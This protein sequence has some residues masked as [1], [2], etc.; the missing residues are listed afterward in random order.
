MPHVRGNASPGTLMIRPLKRA[1]AAIAAF[2]ALTIGAA[3]VSAQN[4]PTERELQV[5]AGLH[6]AAANGDVKELEELISDGEKIDLQDAS[7][8]TPLIVAA[9][10]KQ[11]AAAEALL[12]HGANVNAHDVQ[13]Y[14]ILTIAA[15]NNDVELAKLALTNGANAGAVTGTSSSTALISAAHLG[16]VEIL[17]LLIDAKAPLDH[18]NNIGWT[19]LITA[20]V[21]GN[22]SKEHVATVEALVKAGAN[23]DIKDRGGHT[24]LDYARQ[25]RYDDMVKIIE[26]AKG[27]KL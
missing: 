8:R 6:A 17:R 2:A 3:P 5:Y 19:A 22:G 4:P 10:R 20:V 26:P 15:V 9:F 16:H 24:A 7:S 1:A 14:D 12:K 27:R 25:R 13:G 11:Y 18:V 23:V 21:L